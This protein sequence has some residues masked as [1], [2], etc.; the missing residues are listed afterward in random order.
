MIS[1]EVPLLII[2]ATAALLA[3]S[4]NIGDI[5]MAQTKHFWYVIPMFVGFVTFMICATAESERAPF[6]LAEAESELV[7]G[8]QTEYAGMKWGLIMLGDY[9]RGY[10]ACA[11]V[12]IMFLGGW[13]MPFINEYDWY[14]QYFPEL[15]FVLKTCFVFIAFIMARG[16]IA[17]VRTDQIL[18]I[19][20]RVLMPF[21]VINLGVAILL[22]VGGVF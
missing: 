8:W 18:N 14:Y 9:F 13:S 15:F 17:R 3:G 20:W 12:N 10:V 2:I 1:Y 22:K 5:V 7:E 6:D 4:L 11:F 19:G 16:A 21:A